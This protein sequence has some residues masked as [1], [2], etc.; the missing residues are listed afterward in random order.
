[1]L[2]RVTVVRWCGLAFTFGVRTLRKFRSVAEQEYTVA[3][4][5]FALRNGEFGPDLFI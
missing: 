1:V 5:S 2:T 4:T 3:K